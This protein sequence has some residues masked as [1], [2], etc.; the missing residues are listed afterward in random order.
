M[1][2]CF[3]T[4]GLVPL[5]TAMVVIAP[6]A[7]WAQS[8]P[9]DI[10]TAFHE[11]LLGVMKKAKTLGVKGRFEKLASPLKQNFHFRLMTQVAAGSYWRKSG[12]AQIDRLVD[13]FARLS[14]STYASRFDGYSGQSFETEGEKP[15]PQKT[16]LVK[17]RIIDPGSDP[18]DL[19][20]VTRKIKGEWRIIDVLLDVGISELAVRR[21]EYRR[22][23]KI[24]GIEG[25]IE[26]LNRK[27][28]Q[29]LNP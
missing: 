1:Q 3:F 28:D 13:A 16:I 8:S 2:R 9:S 11:S 5:L 14:I 24:G 6:S 17:T 21:S 23:L 29:L 12:P 25:L 20:Y 26:T 27:A 19:T 10:V 7:G 22:V 15:G 4:F 18:V